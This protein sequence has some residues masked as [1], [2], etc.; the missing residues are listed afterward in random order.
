MNAAEKRLFI[1]RILVLINLGFTLSLARVYMSG[2][3]K[4]ESERVIRDVELF[5]KASR[6]Q[7]LILP[8]HLKIIEGLAKA[9]SNANYRDSAR[10]ELNPI[11]VATW[12]KQNSTD[13][14][15]P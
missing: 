12:I 4:M 13:T 3:R 6:L 7:E 15:S 5:L 14:L 1:I 8:E 10:G 11:S 2:K 9:W